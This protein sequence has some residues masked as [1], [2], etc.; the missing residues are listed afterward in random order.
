MEIN[1]FSFMLTEHHVNKCKMLRETKQFIAKMQYYI[2]ILDANPL[3][4]SVR[5]GTKSLSSTKEATFPQSY[6]KC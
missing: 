2:V 1:G 5:T 6:W 3:S 4:V